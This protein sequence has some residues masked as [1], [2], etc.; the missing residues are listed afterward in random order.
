MAQMLQ[1]TISKAIFYTKLWYSDSSFI[2]GSY[3]SDWHNK[4]VFVQ[5]MLAAKQL[6]K[7]NINWTMMSQ[8]INT[9]MHHQGSLL[10]T[11]IKFT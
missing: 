2:I 10:S 5:A 8:F 9:E 11:W 4:S 3:E 6:K 1:I 7:K